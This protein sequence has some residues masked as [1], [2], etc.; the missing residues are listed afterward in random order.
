MYPQTEIKSKSVKLLAEPLESQTH[1]KQSPPDK[2]TQSGG[3]L[4]K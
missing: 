1:A 3:M 2:V 4:Q